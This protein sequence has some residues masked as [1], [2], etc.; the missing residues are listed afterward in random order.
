MAVRVVIVDDQPVVRAGLVAFLTAQPD[1]VVVG[2]A[3][4]GYAAIEVVGA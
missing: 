3:A 2:E 4:D 1:L